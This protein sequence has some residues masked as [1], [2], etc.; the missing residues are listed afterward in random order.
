[1]SSHSRATSGEQSLE[2]LITGTPGVG[3]TT[4][5]GK[6]ASALGVRC[7]SLGEI[8]ANT[9]YV[10]HLRELQTHEIIDME[11]AKR[12]VRSLLRPGDI[13]DTHV[14]ELVSSVKLAIVLRKAPDVLFK[15]LVS[16]GWPLRKVLD[17][18][19]AEILDLVYVEAA[20][21][22]RVYQ[23]DVTYRKPDETSEILLKCVVDN[24]CVDEPVDW[25]E[26]SER[27]GFLRFIE[28]LARSEF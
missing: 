9:P 26:Y 8:L 15:E 17:N 13:V 1:M 2:I 21:R 22:W 28:R 4:Q 23:I 18:V 11:G 5:C 27:T 16:R 14:V 6:L 3:K 20:K 7:V 10:K 19:W 25:L 24:I 12:F